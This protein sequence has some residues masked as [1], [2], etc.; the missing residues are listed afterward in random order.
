MKINSPKEKNV[1]ARKGKIGLDYFPHDTDFDNELEYLIA[2]HKETGY[3]VYFRLL[4]RLYSV[5]GYYYPADKKSLALLSG[6]INVDINKITD[7]INDCLSEHLF[8]KSLHK[9]YQILTSRGIQKRYF[10]AINRRNEVQIITEYILIDN[11]YIN[12]LNVNI[13]QLNVDKSTQSKVKESKVK[14]NRDCLMKNSGVTI[15]DISEAFKKSSDLQKADH[16]HYFN[17]VLDWS[18]AN[19]KLKTDWIAAVRNWARSDLKDG[20]LKEG[21]QRATNLIK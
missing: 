17:V 15:E 21:F 3:Y 7:V 5:Y 8:D 12:K 13:I 20:K 6:K 2:I 14:E 1:M 4:E 11:E 16:R 10:E 19:S 9:K 18:T